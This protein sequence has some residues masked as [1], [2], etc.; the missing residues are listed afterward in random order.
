MIL[1]RLILSLADRYGIGFFF[2]C[3]VAIMSALSEWVS[4]SVALLKLGPNAAA[5]LAF[6]VATLVN[7][8]LSRRTF[9][10]MRQAC[11]EVVL[12]IMTSGIAFGFNFFC[13]FALYYFAGI[14]ILTAKVSG[15]FV[16]FG[17]NYIVR[18]F[19][20]FSPIPLHKPVSVV[21]QRLNLRSDKDTFAAA[22]RGDDRSELI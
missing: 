11:S 16:G 13:F 21:V 15:T 10:S 4:F 12:I 9:R 17:F 1:R 18:Q 8:L 19:F 22:V 7:S 2:Y 3:G 5:I 20:I 14:N 6:F